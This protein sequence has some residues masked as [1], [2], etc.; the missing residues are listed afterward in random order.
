MTKA[1]IFTIVLTCVFTA[2]SLAAEN[3]EDVSIKPCVTLTGSDSR[4]SKPSFHR[5]Q[6]LKDWA[7]VWAIHTGQETVPYENW[8]NQYDEFYN[9]L[10]LPMIDFGNYM[11]VAIFQGAGSNNAGLNAVSILNNT[12]G[13]TFRFENKHFSTSGPNG[14]GKNVNVYGFFVIPRSTK[15]IIVEEKILGINRD[16]FADAL[17]VKKPFDKSKLYTSKWVQRCKFAESK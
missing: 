8:D 1:A 10:N 5:V 15:P 11:V 2:C 16:K 4:V 12:D 14:G 17:N 7:K 9:P 6:S 3:N 13:I